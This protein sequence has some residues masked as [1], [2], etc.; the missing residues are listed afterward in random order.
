LR[1]VLNKEDLTLCFVLR[2]PDR[3]RGRLLR[4]K[5]ST[6]EPEEEDFSLNFT[7]EGQTQKM[8][9]KVNN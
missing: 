1:L 2:N 3:E 4:S 9:M 7:Q 5:L 8:V 6:L